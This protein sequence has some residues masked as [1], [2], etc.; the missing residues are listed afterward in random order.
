MQSKSSFPKLKNPT[1]LSP[2]A[3]VTDIAFRTLAKKYGAALTC[4]EFVSSSGVIRGNKDT[5]DLLRIHPSEKPVAVQIFGGN[6]TEVVAAGKLLEKQFD[7][8]D[9]NCGCPVYKVIKNGAGS[10][11]LKKPVFLSK[12]LNKLTTAVNVPVSVKIRIGV[13]ETHINAL[14][15]A[16]I[17]QDAGVAAVTVH[18]RTQKQGYSGSADWD[19]IKKVKEK[20]SIPVFGNGDVFSPETFKNCLDESGVDG[21]MIGR[22]AIGNP[23]C[24]RQILDYLKK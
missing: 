18:G 3:G 9:F 21:I 20:L 15:I 4:T 13:D 16:K 19:L 1:I 6:I 5:L 7:I 23:Y 8:I 11:L 12:L 14:E 24:F 10:G 22:F 17:A 2:M